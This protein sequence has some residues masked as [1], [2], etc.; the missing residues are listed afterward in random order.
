MTYSIDEKAWEGFRATVISR[1]RFPE[2]KGIK[3]EFRKAHKLMEKMIACDEERILVASMR[4]FN[5]FLEWTYDRS[6]VSSTPSN[7]IICKKEAE[8]EDII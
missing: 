5:A 2:L 8:D 3:K 4:A 7:F 1:D 6:G